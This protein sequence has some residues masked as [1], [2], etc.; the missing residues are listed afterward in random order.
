MIYTIILIIA[1]G[2]LAIVG[3]IFYERT[4]THPLRIT[5]EKAREMIKN[6]EITKVVDVRTLVEWNAGHYPSA[7]HI[8]VD[9]LKETNLI[10]ETDHILIY[11]NTGTRARKAA[12][13]LQSMGYKNVHYIAET[14]VELM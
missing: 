13:L 3:Y 14:Y 7:I 1:I 2:L 8:P 6:G 5:V 10:T 11:C 12:E 9:K 4:Y